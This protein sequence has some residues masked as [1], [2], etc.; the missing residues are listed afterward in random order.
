VDTNAHR[1][2]AALRAAREARELGREHVAAAMRERGY[3]TVTNTVM[4]W[5]ATGRVQVAELLDLAAVLDVPPC[6]LLAAAY[7]PAVAA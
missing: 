6:D 4:R 5:E 1:I 2:G 3:S 7:A